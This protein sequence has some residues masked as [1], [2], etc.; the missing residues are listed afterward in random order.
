MK[1]GCTQGFVTPLASLA[2]SSPDAPTDLTWLP[3]IKQH[4]PHAWVPSAVI[5]DK[6]VKHNNAAV[7]TAMWDN[8][9]T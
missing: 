6:A 1:C 9:V 7:Q 8:R 5:M 3:G 2:Y 4:L